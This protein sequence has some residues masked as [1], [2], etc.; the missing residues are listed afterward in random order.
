MR[1]WPVWILK[2]SDP[3]LSCVATTTATQPDH[4]GI[5]GEDNTCLGRR[6][7][8]LGDASGLHSGLLCGGLRTGFPLDS[9]SG[10]DGLEDAWLGVASR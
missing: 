2:H 3:R 6:A 1:I 9:R 5:L 4:I 8:L 7:L 10:V